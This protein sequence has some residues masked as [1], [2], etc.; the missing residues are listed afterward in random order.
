M[1]VGNHSLSFKKTETRNTSNYHSTLNGMI[2]DK[3]DSS[4][5][6][7]MM[8]GLIEFLHSSIISSLSITPNTSKRYLALKPI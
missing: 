4:V 8:V 6:D 7:L 2:T 5:G 3:K 1:S